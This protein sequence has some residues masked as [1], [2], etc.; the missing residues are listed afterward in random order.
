MI[1]SSK[2][3]GGHSRFSLVNNNEEEILYSK[4]I[5]IISNLFLLFNSSQT[6]R[7]KHRL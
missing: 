6:I 3:L 4:Y 1:R 7:I 5:S 2:I